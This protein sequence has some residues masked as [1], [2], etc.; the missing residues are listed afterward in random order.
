MVGL[1]PGKVVMFPA[2]LR[3]QLRAAES[4]IRIDLWALLGGEAAGQ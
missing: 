3:Y 4:A 1:S 2:W